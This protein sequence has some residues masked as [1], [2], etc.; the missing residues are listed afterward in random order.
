MSHYFDQNPDTP[1]EI[2]MAE[3]N[4]DG[5]EFT[6]ATDHGVFSRGHVDKGTEVLLESVVADLKN[7][8]PELP[9]PLNLLDLACGYGVLG[10]ALKRIYPAFDLTLTD[11]NERALDLTRRNL[12]T[13]G[14]RYADVVASD[15]FAAIGDQGYSV[16]VSNPP[17]R[18]GKAT[19]R[20]M[21]QDASEHLLVSGRFYVVLGKKQGAASYSNYLDEL[22]DQVDRIGR[23]QGF[24]VYRCIKMK[25]VTL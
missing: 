12:E 18:A 15:G 11:V 14:V 10:I 17:I 2:K 22:F 9:K 3:L 20:K 6:F 1:S 23:G 7:A 8:E 16:I 24:N 21:M 5:R 4:I 19:V 25:G 13:N